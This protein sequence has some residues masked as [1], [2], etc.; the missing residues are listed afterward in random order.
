MKNKNLMYFFS[1]TSI[2][3][4]FSSILGFIRDMLFASL[5]GAS[6][7]YDAFIIASHIP[8]FVTYI[9]TEAGLTQTFTPLLSKKQMT[10]TTSQLKQFIA[11]VFGA[12]LIILFFITIISIFFSPKI[13]SLFA[14]GFSPENRHLAIFLFQLLAI[15]ML[16]STISAYQS[17]ILNSYGNYGLPASMP[18]L[19]NICMI[20]A[21]IFL[22]K[23][24]NISVYALALGIVISSIL[25]VIF[26]SLALFKKKLLVLPQF[27]F[28]L[29]NIRQLTK[30][31]LPAL[32]GVS[33][34]QA[35]VMIDLIF[36]SYLPN[37]SITWL[38]YSTRIMELP[39]TLFAIGIATVV[40]PHL[41]RSHAINNA[42]RFQC[43]LDWA[44]RLAL[45][46]SI[47][48]GLGLLLLAYP[49]IITLFNHGQFD[50]HDTLMTA[51]ST[52]AFSIAIIGFTLTKVC[53]TSFYAKQ[54]ISLP[55]KIISITVLLNIIFNIIFVSKY[56]HVG[57]AL[58]TSLSSIIS[59]IILFS[60]LLKKKYYQLN[61]FFLTHLLK[62]G[63]AS[64]TMV[65]FLLL[66][67]PQQTKWIP[68]DATW[69]IE[70][71]LSITV[72]AII[73]YL[74]TLRIIGFQ[75]RS[76]LAIKSATPESLP[77]NPSGPPSS[78]STQSTNHPISTLMHK[79]I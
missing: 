49:I 47:P 5:F 12:L 28:Q 54:N 70:H 13:I 37:G 74:V 14:P 26:L 23:F 43:I 30:L 42:D 76:I 22:T 33:A 46:T 63:I 9:I 25:Q 27:H 39:V 71:L 29:N 77:T 19:F 41:G 35:G 45:M 16:F 18:I 36:G 66:V 17:A 50:Y 68:A 51:K 53:A 15:S 60:L 1:L 6:S 21:A 48:A 62:I 11:A 72:S 75:Y 64:T 56:Q 67:T 59:A 79:L 32:L 24:F 78:E 20:C 73:V 57:L 8:S 52:Q 3:R 44:M 2:N 61:S 4:I 7:S 10:A 34:M 31:I 40:L 65:L 38:Y 55:A 69:R 58:A